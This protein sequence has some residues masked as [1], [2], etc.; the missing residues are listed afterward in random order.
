M[1]VC[2]TCNTFLLRYMAT[3]IIDLSNQIYPTNEM[4]ATTAT[5]TECTEFHNIQLISSF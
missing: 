4:K 2:I 5:T 3:V 1:T